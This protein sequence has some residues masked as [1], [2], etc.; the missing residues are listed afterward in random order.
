MTLQQKTVSGVLWTGVAKMSMQV[1]L[2]LVSFVLARLLTPQAFGVVGMAALVTVAITLVNDKGLGMAL[3]QRRDLTEL[4]VSSLFWGGM[5]F[6]VI[7]YGLSFAAAGPLAAFFNEP[8]LKPVVRVQ[9]FGFI[10]SALGI[11]QKAMMT[12]RMEFRKLA[13]IEIIALLCSAVVAVSMAF[14][15]YGVWSLVA[16]MLLRDFATIVL[17]WFTFPWLPDWRFSWQAFRDLAVFSAAVLGNDVAL[18]AVTN[19]D[20]TIIGRVL[21]SV[22]LGYYAWAMNLI[23]F[24]ITRLSGIVSRV[25]F[26]AFSAMQADPL[27]FKQGYL[28]SIRFVAL[29]TFPLL[30][31]LGWSAP[32]LVQVVLGEQWRAVQIPL[33]LLVP[34]GML[35]SVGT[36]KGAVLMARGKPEIE[37][38]WNIAYLIPLVAA[39]WFGTRYG[40]NGVAAAFVVL[41]ILTFPIIQGITHRQ[42]QVT[43]SEF[44]RALAPATTAA[45]GLS[46]A[47]AAGKIAAIHFLHLPPFA[48]LF[49]T[50][51]G[52]GVGY[53]STL[54]LF[55]KPVVDEF[56]GLFLRTGQR[57]QSE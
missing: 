38:K 16:L 21:G 15:G 29:I 36:L 50:I 54:L 55:T 5:A 44:G 4:S 47:C 20:S 17:L 35:K 26:P 49:I 25:T 56:I 34:M 48:V 45:A 12:R 57:M 31:G 3:V 18:Y 52:G 19:T 41:Y 43:W 46:V 40:L 8:M 7:L 22:S 37:L 2:M 9:A 32:E 24:P 27:R 14:S 10:V 1:V 6:S 28:K 23:K 39:V 42:I 51:V 30:V 13:I 53:V 33:M 11:V